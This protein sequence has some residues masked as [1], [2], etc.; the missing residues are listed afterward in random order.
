[1]RLRKNGTVL[2]TGASGFVGSAV[3][4]ALRQAGFPVR[5]LVRPGSPTTHLS[6]LGLD[7]VRG[8]LRDAASLRAAM[9]GVRY[10]FHVAADYRLWARDP[11]ELARPTSKARGR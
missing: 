5:A 10:L 7:F 3:A 2:L 4:L 8:D 6:E 9:S 11:S 1:M